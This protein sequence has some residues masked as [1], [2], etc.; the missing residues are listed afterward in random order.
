MALRDAEYVKELC[1]FKTKARVYEAA[2]LG[3][4]PSVRIGRQVRFDED[5][6]RDWIRRGGSA[7]AAN[8]QSAGQGDEL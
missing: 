5:S 7:Q 3:L 4:I 8:G 2:R 1:G 6:L